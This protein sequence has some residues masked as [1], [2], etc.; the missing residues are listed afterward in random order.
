MSRH[1]KRHAVACT[2][3]LVYCIILFLPMFAGRMPYQ[4]DLGRMTGPQMAYYGKWL[5]NGH[6]PLWNEELGCG[7]YQHA[8]GQNAMYYPFNLLLYRVFDWTLALRL[9]MFVHVLGACV[10]AY[11]IGM[12]LRLRR[13]GA[14]LFALCVGG[15]GIMAAHQIHLN[16]VLGL[17]NGLL[18][19]LA[20]VY[21]ISSDAR[22]LWVLAGAV[23]VGLALLGGQPQYLWLCALVVIVIW[24]AARYS[25]ELA[26]DPP[27]RMLKK[28]VV[29]G[30]GGLLIAAVQVIPMWLYARTFPRPEP[31][32]HYAF[33]TAGSFQWA[34]FLHFLTPAV[35]LKNTEGMQYWE[36]LGYIGVI[37]L[38]VIGVGVVRGWK[39]NLHT[40]TAFILLGLGGVLMLG[41]NTPLYR[42]LQYIPPF[43][44]FRV[45]GRAVL[46]FS[47]G[48]A[49]LAAHC[50]E[51]IG[52]DP[53]RYRRRV[54]HLAVAVVLAL[55]VAAS[56][57]VGA[58]GVDLISV[59]VAVLLLVIFDAGIRVEDV[60]PFVAH[61][62]VGATAVQLALAWHLLNPTVPMRFWTNPPGAATIV[63]ERT[64]DFG[65]R[66]ACMQPGSPYWPPKESRQPADWR[67]RLAHNTCSVW[68]VPSALV[69]E[70]ILPIAHLSINQRLGRLLDSP[71]ELADFCTLAG[72]RWLSMPGRD[73]GPPWE[74]VEGMPWLHENPRSVG[75]CYT[76]RTVEKDARGLVRPAKTDG[77]HALNPVACKIDAPGHLRMALQV[78][79]PVHLFIV[80]GVYP[81]WSCSLDGRPHPI[82]P[83]SPGLFWHTQVPP[84]QHILQMRFEPFGLQ[85]G[86]ILTLLSLGAVAI[87]G[88]VLRRHRED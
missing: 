81:G 84:G 87:A 78:K 85:I 76:T 83:A 49:L 39:W 33:I 27:L 9:S 14:V 86:L 22:P 1:M 51:R 2:F 71:G 36:T 26:V 24:T 28:S 47:F 73:L 16:I 79:E 23:T 74:Q 32:G 20:A 45:P 60:R 77:R 63:R 29:V 69:A 19:I 18:M 62:A 59:G 25:D 68:G 34:D 31:A 42:L 8:A 57:L 3:L 10:W 13:T 61:I 35:G 6:I 44:M 30:L 41:S 46:L 50:L 52:R 5:K 11:L 54:A 64:D 72:I 66:V 65:Q 43:S 55:V 17:C 37:P 53:D 70:A 75:G 80:Q 38:V 15:G 12:R 58:D 82:D 88:V 40:R 48:L 4:D 7:Y 67:N 56:V 21:W